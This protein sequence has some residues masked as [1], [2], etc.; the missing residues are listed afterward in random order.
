MDPF[1]FYSGFSDRWYEKILSENGFKI[2][3]IVAAGDYYSWLA[4]EMARTMKSHS[5]LAKLAVTPAFLYF[6]NKKKTA[7]STD[8][9]CMGYHVLA[10]KF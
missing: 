10:I 5:F 7:I 9:L 8:I 2:E 6:Y 4:L 1:F 3:T